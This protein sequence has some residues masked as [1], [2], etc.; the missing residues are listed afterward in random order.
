M[1]IPPRTGVGGTGGVKI[2]LNK[3]NTMFRRDRTGKYAAIV[4]FVKGKN[5][6]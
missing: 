3:D 6:G 4:S 5:N 2:L 1:I